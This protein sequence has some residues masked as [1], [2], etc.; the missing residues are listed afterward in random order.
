L[1][2]EKLTWKKVYLASNVRFVQLVQVLR[3][4]FFSPINIWGI[5]FEIIRRHWRHSQDESQQRQYVPPKSPSL[6][7][8]LNGA[9][10]T[11]LLVAVNIIW[12]GED[13]AGISLDIIS[14]IIKEFSCKD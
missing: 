6:L 1:K 7:T 9:L 11:L 12:P 3:E 10:F 14:D 4:I 8:T 5:M 13:V 2:I